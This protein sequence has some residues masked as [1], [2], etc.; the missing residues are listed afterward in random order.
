M[1][2]IKATIVADSISKHRHRLTSMVITIPRMILAELNTHRMLSKNTSS[3]RAIPFK[4]MVEIVDN[5]PFIPIAWQEEHKGMQGTKYIQD[6][7]N[8]ATLEYSWI[9]AKNEAVKYAKT[10]SILGVTKQLCNRLL[11]PFMWCTVLITGTEWENFFS[12]RCPQYHFG[13]KV[14]RSKKDALPTINEVLGECDFNNLDDYHLWA[15]INQGQAEIH[16]M[17]LAEKMWDALNENTP[18]FLYNGEWHIPF[19]NSIHVPTKPFVYITSKKNG[20]L[21]FT[22]PSLFNYTQAEL[23]ELLLIQKLKVSVAMA[24]RTSYT[25]VGDEKEFG[26]EKQIELY[27]RL[28]KGTP[29]HASPF[30]HCARVLDDIE[31]ES[32]TINS[33]NPFNDSLDVTKGVDKNYRGY[34]QY[35]TFLEKR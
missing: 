20:E 10:L 30:E 26:Y 14:F 16:I 3:S 34:L 2:N 5:N 24:A 13:G 6:T 12:L 15:S 33:Y 23:D 35:R 29:L 18:K 28:E 9:K 11:E 1:N 17:D 22:E 27:H 8:I 21:V 4:K 31:Y 32:L 25:T 19:E 7:N